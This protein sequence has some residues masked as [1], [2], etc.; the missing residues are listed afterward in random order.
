MLRSLV[1]VWELGGGPPLPG[2]VQGS[3]VAGLGK[4]W[5]KWRERGGGWSTIWHLGPKVGIPE[6]EG[7]CRG[8]TMGQV[9]DPKHEAQ[10][11]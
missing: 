9:G 3:L 5:G 2:V 11:V 6:L 1:G 7:Q 4:D 10:W 8:S